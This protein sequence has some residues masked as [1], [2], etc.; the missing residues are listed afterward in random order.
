MEGDAV[1]MTEARVGQDSDLFVARQP[2]F[3]ASHHLFAYE[4]LFR[5]GPENYFSPAGDPAVPTSRVISSGMFVG[6]GTLTAGKPAFINFG[7]E[8]LLSGLC[9]ALPPARTVVELLESVTPDEAA[10]TACRQLKAKGYRIALDDFEDRADYG[11][12]VDLA[13]FIKVDVLAMTGAQCAALGRRYGGSAHKVL[14]EKV[15]TREAFSQ[16]AG[17]GYDYFQGFFFSRPTIVSSKTVPAYRLNYLRLLQALNEPDTDIRQL[18]EIVKKEVSLSFRLLQRVNSAAYSFTQTTQTLRHALVLL[19]EREIRMCATIWA[20]AN[21]AKDTPS[22]IIVCSTLRGRLCEMLAASAGLPDAASNLF[23]VGAFSLLDVILQRPLE[24]VVADLPVSEDVRAALAGEPNR[25]RS[26]LDMV[27]AYE[28][29]DWERS[30]ALAAETGV[31]DGRLPDL[32]V[33]AIQWTREVFQQ[34]S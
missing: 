12:L 5:S 15:E 16:F 18:E 6:L 34:A 8:A 19:G 1:S 13:D 7:R 31:E 11:P 26:V 9:Y 10:V 29:G 32:Y 20:L 21:L 30:A 27:M 4:L 14:A 28:R 24:E 2:I 17:Y 25:L 3:D 22:E 23:L 33:Q